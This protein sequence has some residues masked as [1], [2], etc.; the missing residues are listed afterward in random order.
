MSGLPHWVSQRPIKLHA[1]SASLEDT[2]F[3]SSV[4]GD[5][6]RRRPTSIR[7]WSDSVCS[8]GIRST[9]TDSKEASTQHV[10][11]TYGPTA[12]RMPEELFLRSRVLRLGWSRK[13]AH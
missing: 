6:R 11:L 1:L 5:R 2:R 13:W 4:L 9:S 12:A 3:S 8:S 7:T 10:H